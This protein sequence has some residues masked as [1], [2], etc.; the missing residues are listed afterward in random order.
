MHIDHVILGVSDLA[1]GVR[2]FEA[3]TGVAA[4]YGGKHPDW[5]TENALVSL[6]ADVYLEVIAPRR[7]ERLDPRVAGLA[8]LEQLAPFGFAVA[9]SDP[10][11]ARSRL[12]EAGVQTTEPRAG[13]RQTPSGIVL[14]WQTFDVVEPRLR[15]APFFIHWEDMATHPARTSPGG[16]SLL[17]IELSEP[18]LAALEGLRRALGIA[19]VTRVAATPGIALTLRC[20]DRTAFPQRE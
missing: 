7:G 17:R 15:T 16:C 8:T 11:G 2:E 5:G 4:V 1:T 20:G 13:S 14:R 6:G 12:A 3:A 19:I 10:K 9:V 18:D